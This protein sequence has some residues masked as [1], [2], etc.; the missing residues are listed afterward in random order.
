MININIKAT[1]MEL[2]PAIRDY[3]EKRFASLEKFI[4]HSPEESP[5]MN[6]EVGKT[7]NHHKHGDVYKSEVNLLFKGKTFYVVS[8]KED[9]YAAIDDAKEDLE[10]ELVSK[11]DKSMTLY[12]RGAARVKN[13]LKGISNY[14]PWRK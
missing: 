3:V 1:N 5:S 13:L 6:I 7:T 14:R 2:T 12:K 8:E 10:R 9:L 4:V 11:K